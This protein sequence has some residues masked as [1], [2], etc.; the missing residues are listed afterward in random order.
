MDHLRNGEA[1][2]KGSF[3]GV[4]RPR[5]PGSLYKVN[6]ICGLYSDFE[7]EGSRHELVPNEL[8]LLVRCFH[9]LDVVGPN[10]SLIVARGGCGY[11]VSS[12]LDF[13]YEA[14]P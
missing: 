10:V 3:S 8:V 5:L 11:V 9:D 12:K 4:F 14:S 13:E 7:F 2:D 1:W 6:Q